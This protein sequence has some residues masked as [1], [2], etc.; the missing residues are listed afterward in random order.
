MEEPCT[1]HCMTTEEQIVEPPLSLP[2]GQKVREIS[3]LARRSN[4][5]LEKSGAR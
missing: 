1:Q 5:P 3:A 4:D 2:T